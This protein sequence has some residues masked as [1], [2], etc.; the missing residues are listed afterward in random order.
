MDVRTTFLN[1][2]LEEEVYM[3]Q[4]KCFILQGNEHKMCRLV[5]SL[6]G[7]KQAPKQWHEKFDKV[8]VSNGFRHNNA[9]KYF[10]SK[11]CDDYAIFVCLYV[12]DMLILSNDM[13]GIMEMKRF[14]FSNFKIKDLGDVHTILGIK[15][16]RNSGGL[17]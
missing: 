2:D 6:Y 11:T 14:Q 12:D 16:R 15:V 17:C 5:K 7:L 8:I 3:E 1:G 4:P 10:Y 13:N 9:D